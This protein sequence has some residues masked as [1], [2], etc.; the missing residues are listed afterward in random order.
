MADFLLYSLGYHSPYLDT[1]QQRVPEKLKLKHSKLVGGV[2]SFAREGISSGS[3]LICRLQVEGW[4]QKVGHRNHHVVEI[5]AE[6][7][8]LIAVLDCV[9][10]D[11]SF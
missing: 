7:V 3:E 5:F 2:S 4:W 11:D 9:D 1:D 10:P 6:Y 8:I